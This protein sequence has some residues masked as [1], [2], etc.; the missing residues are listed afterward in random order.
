MNDSCNC[1]EEAGK[2]TG[3]VN[4]TTD[5]VSSLRTTNKCPVNGAKGKPVQNQTVKALLKAWNLTA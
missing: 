2:A 4:L 3:E 5:R 1:P